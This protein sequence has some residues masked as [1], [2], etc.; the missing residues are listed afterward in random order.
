M[1]E[2]DTAES[3]IFGD[4]Q[5]QGPYVQSGFA[6][7]T[8]VKWQVGSGESRSFGRLQAMGP[9]KPS[10][11]FERAR[12]AYLLRTYGISNAHYEAMKA[13]QGG[14]CAICGRQTDLHVDHDHRTEA[15]RGL[16][17]V[18]CNTGIGQLGDNV[19]GLKAALEYLQ[20]AR[21]RG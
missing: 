11:E 21:R 6:H 20:K 19:R 12:D 18:R 5:A 7:P 17:C 1:S 3:R 14:R 8:E 13:A 10:D 16:L 9:Y 15:V 4:L 2:I